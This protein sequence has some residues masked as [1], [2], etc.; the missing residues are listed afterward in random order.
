M[1]ISKHQ[2]PSDAAVAARAGSG[3]GLYDVDYNVADTTDKRKKRALDVN[4][5]NTCL[6]GLAEEF[7]EQVQCYPLY[8]PILYPFSSVCE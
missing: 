5:Y 6:K 7:I 8:D 1:E 4:C 2:G 3:P